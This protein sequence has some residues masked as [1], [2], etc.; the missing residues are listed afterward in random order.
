MKKLQIIGLLVIGLV[1][2]VLIGFRD[3]KVNA[4]APSGLPATVATSSPLL[5]TTTAKVAFATSS[6]ATRIITTAGFPVR[7]TFSDYIAQTP[8]LAIGHWQ[9]ASTTVSYDSGE[10]GCGKVKV[11]SQGTQTIWITESR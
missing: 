7:M 8:T 2:V 6:C 11:W 5:V 9:S 10:Y 1:V 4:E 3:L